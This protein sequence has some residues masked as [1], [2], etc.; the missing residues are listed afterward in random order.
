MISD[1][2]KY[3][4]VSKVINRLAIFLC[5]FFMLF[6]FIIMKRRNLILPVI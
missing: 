1:C 3:R 2:S 4:K 5:L 6:R